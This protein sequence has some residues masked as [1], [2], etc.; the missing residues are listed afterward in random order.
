MARDLLHLHRLQHAERFPNPGYVAGGNGGTEILRLVIRMR[1]K[2][3]VPLPALE[4]LVPH[5]IVV[6]A[7]ARA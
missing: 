5:D 4:N 3:R 6:V 7:E 2:F 1:Q